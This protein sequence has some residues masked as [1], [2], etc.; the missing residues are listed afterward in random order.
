MK[1]SILK[2]D[3][4]DLNMDEEDLAA[5]MAANMAQQDAD[6]SDLMNQ[7]NM[8]PEQQNATAAAEDTDM[9]A[10]DEVQQENV[11][12]A[13]DQNVPQQDKQASQQGKLSQQQQ[14]QQ[15]QKQ[16]TSVSAEKYEFIKVSLDVTA[17]ALQLLEG[18]SSI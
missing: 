8:A 18:A 9:A 5:D 3:V 11:P 14:Q 1:A 4:S 12:P 7:H 13:G 10:A 2:V 16:S 15:Q 6:F 17:C